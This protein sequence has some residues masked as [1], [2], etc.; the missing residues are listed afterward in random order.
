MSLRDCTKITILQNTW[1]SDTIAD[2]QTSS[3]THNLDI[4]GVELLPI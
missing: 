4:Q 3:S 2:N 1:E